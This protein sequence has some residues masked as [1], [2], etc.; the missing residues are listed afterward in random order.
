MR[1]AYSPWCANE[2][3]TDQDRT[4]VRAL[5][6]ACGQTDEVAGEDQ[7]DCFTA[8]TGP[9]PGFV[10]FYAESMV[11]YATSKG[12]DRDVADRAMRQLFHASGVALANTDASPAQ[13]VREMIEY[14]GTTAAGLEA[15]QSNGLADRIAEGLEAAFEKARSLG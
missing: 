9:V 6:G 4:L 11:R 10:A 15:M 3:V 14:A 8:L 7:I 1:L 13:H 2:A 12:V 5:F